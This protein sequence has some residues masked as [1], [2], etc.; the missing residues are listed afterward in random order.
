MTAIGK[1]V[2]VE[3]GSEAENK[4]TVTLKDIIGL[5]KELPEEY[6]NEAYEALKGIKEKSEGEKEPRPIE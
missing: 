5:T 1:S 2:I 3:Q 6:L 4:V